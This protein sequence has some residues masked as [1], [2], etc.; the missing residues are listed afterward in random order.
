ML[1]QKQIGRLRNW[2]H[3]PREMR[4]YWI[5]QCGICPYCGTGIPT[6]GGRMG[7]FVATW[8]HVIPASIMR[9]RARKSN[10]VLAHYS[11]NCRKSDRI[12]TPCEILFSRITADIVHDY[13]IAEV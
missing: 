2:D 7:P 9:T 5:A 4:I 8:D 6:K 12:P 11:C 10:V 13:G 3:F 1:S